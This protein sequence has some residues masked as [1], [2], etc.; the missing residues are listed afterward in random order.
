VLLRLLTWTRP[1]VE[2]AETEVA[3]GHE[4][5]H[6]ELGGEG[7]CGSILR[8]GRRYVGAAM[9]R[10]DLAQEMK[11]P[12]LVA[13][14]TAPASEQ[15]GAIG[16]GPGVLDLVGEQIR[17]AEPLDAQRVVV[18]NPCG[19]I[20]GQGLPQA[21]DAFLD[22]SQRDVHVPQRSHGD[23]SLSRDVPLTALSDRALE[24]TGGVA[25][26]PPH[27][28][29]VREIETSD[30][31]GGLKQRLVVGRQPVDPRCEDRLNRRRDLPR[32][33]TAFGLWRRLRYPI[34]PPIP[35]STWV[36]TRVCTLSSRKKGLPSVR[37]IN[38]RLRGSR[39]PS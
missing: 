39:V 6:V 8:R 12:R 38:T 23:R 2:P 32:L 24:Q 37:S 11:G 14:F 4:R 7:H 19:L 3:V 1:P 17:L 27:A 15:H 29:Q 36:S 10:G 9:M 35:T 20:G 5:A 25:Q 34:G 26:F 31:G 30:D 16:A 21:G 18:P 22:A 28:L 13:A 33:R